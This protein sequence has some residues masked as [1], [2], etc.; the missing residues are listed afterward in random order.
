MALEIG[1]RILQRYRII[2]V[3]GQG[4]MGAIYRALDENLGVE[5]ALKEN[6]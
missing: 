3:L 2:E 5:V 1:S 4:G 6:L